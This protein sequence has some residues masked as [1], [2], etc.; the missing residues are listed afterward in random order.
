MI[1][2]E[3]HPILEK[4][5]EENMVIFSVILK[6]SKGSLRDSHNWKSGGGLDWEWHQESKYLI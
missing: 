5:T 6:P 1:L 3:K 4:V 2:Y